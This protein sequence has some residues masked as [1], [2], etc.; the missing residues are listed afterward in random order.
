[1]PRP[2]SAVDP[3]FRQSVNYAHTVNFNIG[4]ATKMNTLLDEMGKVC[5]NDHLW[6]Y[7]LTF[8]RH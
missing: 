1:M 5:A 7:D 6:S 4:H 3:T 8:T 2:M